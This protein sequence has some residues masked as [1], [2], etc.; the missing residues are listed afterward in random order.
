MTTT[1]KIVSFLL[2]ALLSACGS[3]TFSVSIEEITETPGSFLSLPPTW[4]PSPTA[5]PQSTPTPFPTFTVVPP[6]T[7]VLPLTTDPFEELRSHSGDAFLSPDGQWS[8]DVD[9]FVMK[10]VNQD[11]DKVWTLPCDLF[12][13]CSVV[14]PV[15]WSS[16]SKLLYFAPEPYF[17]TPVGIRLYTA[18]ARI[19]METGIWEKILGETDRYYDF[20][21][22]SDDA[23]LAYTQPAATFADNHSVILSIRNLKDGGEEKYT[24]EGFVGGNIV[25]SPFAPRFVFQIQDPAAGSSIV[26]YD[27]ESRLLKYLVQEEQNHFY[28]SSWGENNLVSLRKIGWSD[29]ALSDWMLNPFTNEINPVPTPA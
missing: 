17:D 19:D 21:V 29:R 14:T 28:L 1:A 13:E 27:V 6:L 10:V 16:D 3:R 4:T 11:T 18:V 23:Y 2:L 25:W 5:A 22:S 26:Y 12:E 24:L 15:T 7:Q 8:A 20:A 9:S